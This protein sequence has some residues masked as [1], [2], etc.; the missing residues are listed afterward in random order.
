MVMPWGGEKSVVHRR[1]V[2]LAPHAG[3]Q[4]RGC[5]FTLPA[6]ILNCFV[7]LATIYMSYLGPPGSAYQDTGCQNPLPTLY[8]LDEFRK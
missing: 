6:V 4:D 2:R 1:L 5:R 7:T 3:Q 8:Q